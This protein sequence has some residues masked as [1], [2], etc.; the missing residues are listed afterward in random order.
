MKAGK[1]QK[2][3]LVFGAFLA[4]SAC[5]GGS[6]SF[7]TDVQLKS[8]EVNGDV[9]AEMTATI[10]MQGMTLPPLSFPISDPSNP[11]MTIGEFAR[12]Q[13]PANPAE[14]IMTMRMDLTQ[15]AA[16]KSA[17]G[18]ALLPN[19]T[20]IPL[21]GYN[22]SDI[23]EFSAFQDLIKIYISL[24][25]TQNRAMMGVAIPIQ[26]L[27]SIMSFGAGANLFPQFNINGVSGVYGVFTG[28]YTGQNG[29]ALFV[30][31][32]SLLTNPTVRTAVGSTSA[33]PI[34]TAPMALTPQMIS[35]QQREAIQNHLMNLAI[36]RTQL[37]IN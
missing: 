3:G 15:V 6:G 28:N 24:D 1:F 22:A 30:D 20:L 32:S 7:V 5:G 27:N 23:L 12:A 26:E 14:A 10:D 21:A 8:Y 18:P 16:L 35:E 9:F 34:M 37:H 11:A 25:T 29:V 2:M 33:T 31:M 19:G 17:G 4:L 36:Q 13:N